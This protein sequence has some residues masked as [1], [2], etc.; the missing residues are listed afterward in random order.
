MKHFERLQGNICEGRAHSHPQ[1]C[2]A[3]LLV[4]SP[5][6]RVSSHEKPTET[7]YITWGE[8][9]AFQNWMLSSMVN[10]TALQVL[11]CEAM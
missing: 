10:Q 3:S 7:L 1:C 6:S 5:K 2:S 4:L 9:I 8:R 11:Q